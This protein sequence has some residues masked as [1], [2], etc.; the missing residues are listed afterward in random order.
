MIP[1]SLAAVLIS[2]KFIIASLFSLG[3]LAFTVDPTIFAAAAVLIISSIAAGAVTVINAIAKMKVD[4]IAKTDIISGHVDGIN[5]KAT[6]KRDADE[7]TISDLR[8]QLA[9]SEGRAKLLAQ[10]KTNVDIA[11]AVPM[12]TVKEEEKI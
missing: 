6:A 12:R 8:Q 7:S 1:Y 4:I 10:A 11:T 2:K 9:D 3:I 5:T